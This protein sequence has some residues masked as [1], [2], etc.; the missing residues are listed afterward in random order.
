MPIELFPAIDLRNGKVVRLLRGDYARQTTYTV[1]PVETAKSFQEMGCRWLHVVDLDGARDGRPSNLDIIEK[2]IRATSLRVEVGGGIRTEETIEY[3]LAVGAERL[4]L[5]TQA[6]AD[7]Q[8]FKA[9]AHDPRFRGRIV[10]GLDARDGRIATHGWT[11]QDDQGPAAVDVARSVDRWPLAA[12][13]YTDIVRD[14]TLTG[15]NI[16]ATRHLLSAVTH[17][18]V[19]HSG[20]VATLDD[21]AALKQLPIAGIIVGRAL[22]EGRFEAREAVKL[23]AAQA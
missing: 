12:I 17:L 10:L 15:P 20:G 18:P 6:V 5:G 14:G 22:Y 1:D 21:I 4:I 2:I 23:L 19:I 16:E 13:I 9:M 7:F 11:A 8:W 3:L